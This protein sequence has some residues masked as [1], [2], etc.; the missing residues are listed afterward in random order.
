ML[1]F[2][3]GGKVNEKAAD[4]FQVV[5]ITAS[6]T[7]GASN[8]DIKQVFFTVF[9]NR[10]M[11]HLSPAS[12]RITS[13]NKPF[14][15]TFNNFKIDTWLN[16][17]QKHPPQLGEQQYQYQHQLNLPCIPKHKR[18]LSTFC[19]STNPSPRPRPLPRKVLRDATGN[20]MPRHR[21]W[22]L[23]PWSRGRH[24]GQQMWKSKTT[25]QTVRFAM[26][27]SDSECLYAR[28]K[29][30]TFWGPKSWFDYIFL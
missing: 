9:S 11:T 13:D 7:N 25:T 21:P 15:S 10:R 6:V 28:N 17:Q 8:S 2:T 4:T 14:N 23:N 5:R 16:Y 20:A 12:A 3:S 22:T 29:T 19:S 26:V 18:A 24:S 27:K 30:V 1:V